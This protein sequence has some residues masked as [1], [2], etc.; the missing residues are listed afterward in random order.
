MTISKEATMAT[1]RILSPT[2]LGPGETRPLAPP[3]PTLAGKVLG[4]RHDAAWLSFEVFADELERLA[5]EQL[6]VARVVRF[7]PGTRIGS[8]EAESARAL[9]FAADVDAAVVGLGT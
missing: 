2:A 7:D 4:I 6:G 3:L 1:I 8:P 5:R 9:E